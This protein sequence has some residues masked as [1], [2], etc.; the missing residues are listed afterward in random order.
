M[1]RIFAVGCLFFASTYAH[2]AGAQSLGHYHLPSTVLQYS[3]HGFGAGYHAP[4]IRPTHCHPPRLQRYVRV[5]GCGPC[6]GLPMENFPTCRGAGCHSQLDRLL[7]EGEYGGS[8]VTPT[9]ATPSGEVPEPLDE[10]PQIPML[11]AP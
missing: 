11:P 2:Q 8:P 3:G 4:M 1:L 9:E 10:S 7:G 6:E 5:P